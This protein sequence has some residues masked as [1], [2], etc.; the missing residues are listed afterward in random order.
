MLRMTV[1]HSEE[2]RQ[3]RLLSF[4]TIVFAVQCVALTSPTPSYPAPDQTLQTTIV[5][6]LDRAMSLSEAGAVIA[7]SRGYFDGER[8]SVRIVEGAAD[9]QPTA[10]VS[11]N[12][13]AIG[14]ASIFD[15]LRARVAGRR[16]VAFASAYTRSPI[17][18]YVRRDSNIRSISDFA[19]K[20][21]AYEAGDPTAII[22]DALLAKSH[23]SKSTVR[24]VAGLMTVSALVSHAIDILPGYSGRESYLLT[25]MGETFDQ[26]DPASFGLHLPGTVYFANEET[27]R[28]NPEIPQKFLRALIRGW[29]TAYRKEKD[30]L[31]TIAAVLRIADVGSLSYLLD[32]QRP[33]L[34]PSGRRFAELDLMDLKRAQAILVQQR[35]I[36]SIPRLANAIDLDIL[37][38]VY[39]TQQ[40]GL[41]VD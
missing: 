29:D 9:R 11:D 32:Q 18:F 13:R 36:A 15:F 37:K 5:Y 10:F 16:I 8:L 41:F 34:R 4:F 35:L 39:R 38:D 20:I 22:F 28:S 7:L 24:E 6:H 25:E 33:L 2:W 12:Q 14:V 31:D 40:K 21:V 23:V 27:L 19:R 17:V 26:I 1:W 30:D 3:S